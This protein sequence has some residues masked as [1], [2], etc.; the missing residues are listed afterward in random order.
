MQISKFTIIVD[1]YPE[2]GK[3]LVFN[4]RTQALVKL[5]QGLRGILDNVHRLGWEDANGHKEDLETLYRMGIIVKDDVDDEER[6]RRFIEQ[7]KYGIKRENLTVSILTTYSCNFACVYCFEES[8]RTS[9][10]KLDKPTADLILAW[11][12]KKMERNGVEQLT[13]NYYGGEP[14][15]NQ[16]IMEYISGRMKPWCEERGV[17]FKVYLQT[18]GVLLT[19]EVLDKHI[20]LGLGGARI[21]MDGTREVHDR[22]R[23][24]RRTGEGTFDRVIQNIVHAVDRIKISIA[25][26]YDGGNP[27]GVLELVDYL[28]EIGILRKL[29]NLIYSP[30][31]PAL[32]PKENAGAIVSPQCMSNYETETLIRSTSVIEE[33]LRKKGVGF[34]KSGLSVSLCPVTKDGGV[35]IDGNG[36]IFKCNSMLGH[37]EFA[38]GDVRQEEYNDLQ[39]KFLA[40]EP[41]KQCEPN[42]PYAPICNTGC[43]L[44][45]F[46]KTGDLM[47][48]SCEKSYMDK[49]I[50]MAVKKEYELRREAAR[51]KEEVAA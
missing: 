23:P 49:F 15:L 19:P 1:D 40:N 12:K 16:S 48:R 33:A 50:P 3:H 22:Q 51:H 29:E 44:F 10:Q 26:G 6:F 9:A 2:A 45:A 5:D 41:W 18:N 37:P 4:T 30:I 17:R 14:L 36:L 32:G 8:T 21:S 43:R 34:L 35:T 20:P 47:A 7:R 24:M 42:C 25:S 13:V 27:E 31:H 39:K 11:V 28:D 46:F 38:V